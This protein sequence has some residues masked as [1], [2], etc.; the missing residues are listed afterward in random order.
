[1]LFKGT[2]LDNFEFLDIPEDYK[3]MFTDIDMIH[4]F[5]VRSQEYLQ[6]KT[7]T[8]PGP[9]FMK[10]ILGEVIEVEDK[11]LPRDCS[12]RYDHLAA[13]G[14]VKRRLEILNT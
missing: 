1:M 5:K 13:M 9:G 10:F 8:H 2:C 3:H 7:K 11:L 4:Q 12:D 6:E 14:R